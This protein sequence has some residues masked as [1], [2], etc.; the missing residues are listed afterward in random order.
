MFW[1]HLNGAG[2]LIDF[3]ANENYGFHTNIDFF[4]FLHDFSSHPIPRGAGMQ[5]NG[6]G[7][8]TIRPSG[9]VNSGKDTENMFNV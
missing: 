2:N 4:H 8:V 1:E 7:S 3:K 6:I 5:L 9:P